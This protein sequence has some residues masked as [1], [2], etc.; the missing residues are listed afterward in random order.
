MKLDVIIALTLAPM[1][2]FMPLYYELHPMNE[3]KLQYL[4]HWKLNI[5]CMCNKDLFI[6]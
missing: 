1:C 3:T 4:S 2:V 5:D 6:S